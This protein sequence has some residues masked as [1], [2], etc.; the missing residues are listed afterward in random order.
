MTTAAVPSLLHTFG[1][2][3]SGSRSIV[4]SRLPSVLSGDRGERDLLAA[5]VMGQL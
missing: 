4:A 1:T 2:R 3:T 5:D